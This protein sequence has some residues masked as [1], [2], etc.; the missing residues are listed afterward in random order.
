MRPTTLHR[1]QPSRLRL[2]LALATALVLPLVANAQGGFKPGVRPTNKSDAFK[3]ALSA[4]SRGSRSNSSTGNDSIASTD[5]SATKGLVY[6]EETPDSVLRMKVFF[7]NYAPRKVKIDELWNPTLDP[8]GAQFSD[9]LE[10]FNGNYYLGQG[11]IGHPH[12]A[13]YPTLVVPLAFALQTDGLTAYLKKPDNLRLHQTLTPYT[14]LSYNNT[15]NKDYLVQITHTQNIRP[16][17]NVA[18]DYRLICPEGNMASSGAKNSQLDVTT[19]YFSKDSRLQAQAGFAWQSFLMDENGG[20]TDDRYFTSNQTSNLSGLPVVL[21]NSSSKNLYHNAFAK[22]TY[23][24][25]QQVETYRNRDSLAV[26]YDTVGADSVRMVVDTIELVDTIAV[27]TPRM[28]N[29][30]VLGVSV[31]Y[32]RWKRSAYLSTFSD[33]TLWSDASATIFWTN[34]AYPDHRWHNPL[35]LT[36]GLTP[37]N[38][39]AIVATD[40]T[41]APDTL[42]A[43]AALNPFAEATLS[44]G[45]MALSVKGEVDNTLLNLNS[46]IHSPDYYAS[47]ALQLLLDSSRNTGMALSAS[48]QRRMPEVRMLHAMDYNME[49]IDAQR[50]GIHL[51]HNSESGVLQCID[52]DVGAT[53]QSHHTWY[54]STLAVV[55]GN[56]DLWLYQATLT[57]RLRLGWLHIDMQQFL[58]HSTDEAQVEVPLWATKNS[59]YADFTLFRRALRMQIGADIRYYTAFASDGYDPATGL[60][61]SQSTETGDYLWADAFINLQVKRASIYIKGGHLNALWESHPNYFLMPHYPGT[62]FGLFWGI[63]WNFFD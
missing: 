52:L 2:S 14:R 61:F 9:P 18:F 54:D 60:F 49:A 55:V 16:G 36:F 3:P 48:L 22:V 37:R 19:N 53:H 23:N 45:R 35:K 15:L 32:A 21:S 46:R 57:M 39:R 41:Q 12:F 11:T 31:D 7:F 33:S 47:G 30:G 5:T 20:L 13:V 26:R 34:D 1:H 6:V 8:T 51:F 17:W 40:T 25:I 28:F 42:V 24:L 58:Q 10:S 44:L 62:R 43:T 59:V 27:G 56:G 50:Y 29:A 4:D 38:L 63:S